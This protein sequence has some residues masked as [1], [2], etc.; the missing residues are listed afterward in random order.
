MN[1][2]FY[3]PFRLVDVKF[4]KDKSKLLMFLRVQDLANVLNVQTSS[5]KKIRVFD[6]LP[7]NVDEVSLE[8]AKYRIGAELIEA[9]ATERKFIAAMD[10][11]YKR[12]MDTSLRKTIQF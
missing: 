2:E 1:Q 10:D 9:F 6:D 12:T 5:Q 7:V 4:N 11:Y 8:H 3:T